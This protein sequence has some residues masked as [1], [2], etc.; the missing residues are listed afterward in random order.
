MFMSNTKTIRTTARTTGYN[1]PV[2]KHSGGQEE[3]NRADSGT[4]PDKHM[5]RLL[6]E[7][8]HSG[9]GRESLALLILDKG[10][11][12]HKQVVG[13]LAGSRHVLVNRVGSIVTSCT[14][15]RGFLHRLFLRGMRRMAGQTAHVC[16]LVML[17]LNESLIF[18]V[19]LCFFIDAVLFC[20]VVQHEQALQVADILLVEWVVLLYAGDDD[21]FRV[22]FC[23]VI[24]R[25]EAVA[26]F[27]RR[28]NPRA[29]HPA[30]SYSSHSPAVYD[31]TADSG[32]LLRGLAGKAE[33]GPLLGAFYMLC[34]RSVASLAP[35]A[36][37]T[38]RSLLRLGI[39]GVV[40]KN[41]VSRGVWQ[42]PH[43]VFQSCFWP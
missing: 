8:R 17:R 24:G 5:R 19:M 20:N 42:V 3:M 10:M 25:L 40:F 7:S 32:L 36:R 37:L 18:L 28:G 33:H 35:D 43:V 29:V 6:V 27:R 2:P 31:I 21:M 4:R 1:T 15:L 22:P 23:P 13:S 11:R 12:T 9:C 38:E 39:L 14:A 16:R 26:D 41:P 30:P 34:S